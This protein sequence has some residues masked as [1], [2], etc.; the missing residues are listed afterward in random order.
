MQAAARLDAYYYRKAFSPP[1]SCFS[2]CRAPIKVLPRPAARL[3]EMRSG[4][5]STSESYM[6]PKHKANK[7]RRHKKRTPKALTTVKAAKAAARATLGIPRPAIRHESTL[8]R[9][10]PKHK[11]TLSDVI[12]EG[13]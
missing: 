2:I 10:Q 6:P 5:L 3:R 9:A 11:S 1:A 12:A 7:A 8:E 13:E 4:E